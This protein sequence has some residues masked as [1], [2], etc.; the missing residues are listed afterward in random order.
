MNLRDETEFRRTEEEK[1]QK[2]EIELL[3]HRQR[4]KIEMELCREEAIQ[5]RETKTKENHVNA[6][7]VKLESDKL[8]ERHKQEVE[9]DH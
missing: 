8:I 6:L 7:K 9:E 5:A 4:M 3:E 2:E 1:R